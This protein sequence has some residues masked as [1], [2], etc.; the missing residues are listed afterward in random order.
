[1]NNKGIA[2]GDLFKIISEGKTAIIHYSFMRQRDKRE[3]EHFSKGTNRA[4]QDVSRISP[5]SQTRNCQRALPARQTGIV[6]IKEQRP[7]CLMDSRVCVI[8]YLFFR[9]SRI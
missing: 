6:A 1:M 3:F 5:D 2:F 9:T 7:G 8:A 4:K